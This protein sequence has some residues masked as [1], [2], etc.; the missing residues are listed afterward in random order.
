MAVLTAKMCL[1]AKAK[2]GKAHPADELADSDDDSKIT[3]G[4]EEAALPIIS[5]DEDDDFADDQGDACKAIPSHGLHA[6]LG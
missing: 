4:H 3:A 1:Q 2:V 6:F 5:E